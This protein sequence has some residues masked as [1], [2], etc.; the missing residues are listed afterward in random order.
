MLL[1]RNQIILGPTAKNEISKNEI[2]RKRIIKFV[3]TK[4]KKRKHS[5]SAIS[6][7]LRRNF[8]EKSGTVPDFWG[9][10]REILRKSGLRIPSIAPEVGSLFIAPEV[11]KKGFDSAR[12]RGQESLS[13]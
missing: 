1:V 8:S 12:H 2:S 9:K 11:G 13:L 7:Q 5:N 10:I 6:N 3:F 4:T